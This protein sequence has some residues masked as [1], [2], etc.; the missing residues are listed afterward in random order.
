MSGASS[1]SPARGTSP[2]R[3]EPPSP[4]Q[5]LQSDASYVGD[6]EPA[7]ST[8]AIPRPP[9]VHVPPSTPD[10][11]AVPSSAP[12]A[13]PYYGCP[14][15]LPANRNAAPTPYHK[16]PFVRG[17]FP[18]LAHGTF[19]QLDPA[20]QRPRGEGPVQPPRQ[21]PVASSPGRAAGR[22]PVPFAAVSSPLEWSREPFYSPRSPKQDEREEDAAGDRYRD[23]DRRTDQDHE[24]MGTTPGAGGHVVDSGRGE[25]EPEGAPRS[26]VGSS[27]PPAA[28][29]AAGY[30]YYM[31]GS[32]DAVTRDAMHAHDDLRT[33]P[34]A[35]YYQDPSQPQREPMTTEREVEITPVFV[36]ANGEE[37]YAGA[38]GGDDAIYRYAARNAARRAGG[39]SD[40]PPPS[41]QN[42]RR[43]LRPPRVANLVRG[44]PPGYPPGYPPHMAAN[45]D[46]ER[47]VPGGRQVASHAPPPPGRSRPGRYDNSLADAQRMRGADRSQASRSPPRAPAL[48][49]Q[50]DAM[51]GRGGALSVAPRQSTAFPR[52]MPLPTP[53]PTSTARHGHGHGAV[54]GRRVMGAPLPPGATCREPAFYGMG[55]L[56][57]G[58]PPRRRR[59]TPQEAETRAAHPR[60]GPGL[61]LE[62][63]VASDWQVWRDSSGY[64]DWAAEAGERIADSQQRIRRRAESR[65]VR[66]VTST[67]S[68]PR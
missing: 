20:V 43:T 29:A 51:D 2:H 8:R 13:A 14:T 50:S 21:K 3:Q 66:Q 22:P 44:M 10:T 6:Y 7:T 4:F 33:L 41:G 53:L 61:P 26:R 30:S 68:R 38:G 59:P 55:G 47:S 18:P 23:G 28:T 35:L 12:R 37:S 27:P 62:A 45:G 39:R 31:L 9:A 19:H 65:A 25:G 60:G 63:S 11:P 15:T 64:V 58:Q 17:A 54:P 32:G 1:G 5:Q 24:E 46:S 57:G 40:I 34:P 16:A 48:Y 42:P 67:E 36:D 56:E 49:H 52:Q